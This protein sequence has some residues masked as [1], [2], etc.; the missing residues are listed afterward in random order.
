M[1]QLELLLSAGFC[2][3]QGGKPV[4]QAAELPV[5]VWLS[6]N[7]GVLLLGFILSPG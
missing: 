5:K 4:N 1:A 2:F 7:R 3:K 6:T